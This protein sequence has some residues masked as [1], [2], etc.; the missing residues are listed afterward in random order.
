VK[1]IVGIDIGTSYSSVS[2]MGPEGPQLIAD[3]HGRLRIPSTLTITAN[4]DVVVGGEHVRRTDFRN[5]V[6][7]ARRLLEGAGRRRSRAE[8]IYLV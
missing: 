7:G 5:T 6:F 2:V 3:E 8:S 1:E 4:G